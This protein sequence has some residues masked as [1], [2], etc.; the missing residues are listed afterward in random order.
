MSS[1]STTT[2]LPPA[3][4]ATARLWLPRTAATTWWSLSRKAG[5]RLMASSTLMTYA[6]ASSAEPLGASTMTERDV[7]MLTSSRSDMSSGLPVRQTI[8]VLPVEPS[9]WRSASSISTLS[10]SAR[11]AMTDLPRL[12]LASTS[13]ETTVKTWSDQPTIT[14]WSLSATG[15]RPL[16]SWSIFWLRPLVSRP[17]SALTTKMP[18]S[19]R[20]NH[21]ATTASGVSASSGTSSANVLTKVCHSSGEQARTGRVDQLQGGA[22]HDQ[23]DE[24]DDRQPAD[25]A[26]GAARHRVVEPIP[27]P[28]PEGSFLGHTY[29]S[30]QQCCLC[31]NWAKHGAVAMLFSRHT[32]WEKAGRTSIASAGRP[33]DLGPDAGCSAD[34][35]SDDVDVQCGQTGKASVVPASARRARSSAVRDRG[36]TGRGAE[37][38]TRCVAGCAQALRYRIPG[39]R[40][41]SVSP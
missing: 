6:S 16:R 24:R 15:E 41:P 37:A 23:H 14:V 5:P 31:P 40:A 26:D 32:V 1:L 18:P 35:A 20:T 13:S 34:P 25:E 33:G 36:I 22:D 29:L 8:R 2:A 27:Q 28:S 12:R 38:S 17:T 19:A 9:R 39:L 3:S 30:P 11:I 10:W 4:L 7:L 21:S